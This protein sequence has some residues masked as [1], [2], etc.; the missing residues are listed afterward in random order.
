M[1]KLIA[2]EIVGAFAQD[3]AGFGVVLHHSLHSILLDGAD[4]H[5][6]AAAQ[7]SGHDGTA[8]LEVE[9]VLFQSPPPDLIAHQGAAGAAV[10]A[11]LAHLAEG[12]NPVVHRRVIGDFGVSGDNHKPAP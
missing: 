10:H 4:L 12:M 9:L 3:L 5:A 1:L 2:F 8:A 11:D 7:V 6:D